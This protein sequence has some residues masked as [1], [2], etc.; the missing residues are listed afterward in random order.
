MRVLKAALFALVLLPAGASAQ[1]HA[2]STAAEQARLQQRLAALQNLALQA[3]EVAAASAALE[4]RLHAAMARLEPVAP[5]RQR[6]S[7]VLRAEVQT[8][9]RARD[10]ARL[11]ALATE[12]AELQ[13][14]FAGLRERALREADVQQ[15]RTAMLEAV[16]ARMKQIDPAAGNMVARL[17][18]LRGGS[19]Q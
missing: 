13:A 19:G 16:V 4:V 11:N 12:A 2:D 5:V 1:A 17:E 8:A 15:A 9:R 6:R 14:F 3:P 7:E 10:Q 18:A